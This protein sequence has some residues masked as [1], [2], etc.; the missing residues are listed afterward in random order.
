[1][2]RQLRHRLPLA[3]L[4]G[5]LLLAQPAGADVGNPPVKLPDMG[6][7]VDR[8]MSASEEQQL[9]A[10][11]MRNV[12]RTLP[13]M[14]D[15]QIN[16]YIQTLGQR[17][18]TFSMQPQR[19]FHFFVINDPA[20]NAF[21]G[22]GGYI[23]VNSGLILAAQ[24]E[25]ELAAVI[26]H[27]LAHVTQRHLA[28][29]YENTTEMSLPMTAAII[30]AIILGSQPGMG[31][32]SEATLMGATAGTLQKQINFTRS[33]EQEA[34]RIGSQTLARAGY[35][36]DAMQRFFTRLLQNNQY[37][38]DAS[39]EFLRTHPL[40]IKRIAGSNNL[41]LASE[42]PSQAEL[43]DTR[44]T[45][46]TEIQH[47]IRVLSSDKPMQLSAYY[48]HLEGDDDSDRYGRALAAIY[49]HDYAGA[50]DRLAA[51]TSGSPDNLIYTLA[52]IEN[53]IIN[54]TAKR[55]LALI[56]D[57]LHLYPNDSPL[58][59]FYVRALLKDGQYARARN[60]LRNYMH[61]VPANPQLYALLAEAEGKYG[62]VSA[63]HQAM[64]EYYF[65][66]GDSGAALRQID[67]ALKQDKSLQDNDRARLESRRREIKQII[68]SEPKQ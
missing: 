19:Q 23:G 58:T 36:A 63:T 28:R 35:A 64:A 10:A 4:T 43:A 40:T 60:V 22:P 51:L 21:A 48:D 8:F 16:R 11:F 66:N 32:L 44:Q 29:A 53:E 37:Q 31:Q 41:P 30:A 46:F 42:T 34:D 57:K 18:A 67:L 27:E 45:Y 38:E 5:T 3:L 7:S 62:D 9:G 1:M 14:D 15:P 26:A 52:A 50:R 17:L 25:D 59:V 39:L 54:G 55:A 12:R 33:N 24:Y 65:L 49:G 2:R 56:N 13:V 20:I 47:R 61:R 68:D 6:E